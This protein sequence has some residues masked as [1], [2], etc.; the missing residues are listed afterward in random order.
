MENGLMKIDIQDEVVVLMPMK[1]LDEV[2]SARFQ[3]LIRGIVKKGHL[4]AVLDLQNVNYLASATLGMIAASIETLASRGGKLVL[5]NVNQEAL[6]ILNVV[7]LEEV[8]SIHTTTEEAIEA[9][10]QLCKSG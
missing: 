9:L 4:F 8:T 3:E 6:R 1:D 7:K 5:S 2:H 10:N